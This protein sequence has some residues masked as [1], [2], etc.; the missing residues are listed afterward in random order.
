MNQGKL[1]LSA[2]YGIGAVFGQPTLTKFNELWTSDDLI[3]SQYATCVSDGVVLFGVHGRQ[4]GGR[5]ALRCLDP[6][7]QKIRWNQPLDN[8]A[9]LIKADGHLLIATVGGELI[10]ATTNHDRFEEVARA[11][12]VQPNSDGSALPALANGLLYVRDAEA[13]HCLDLR[14]PAGD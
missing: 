13:L 3:S 12:V 4:D 2:S 11:R 5:P 9:T 7:T 1:F 6:V 10:L 8:F 14:K